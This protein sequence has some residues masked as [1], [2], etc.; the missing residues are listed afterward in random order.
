MGFQSRR[1]RTQ[2]AI[3]RDGHNRFNDFDHNHVHTRAR[4]L[5]YD[6]RL[7][8]LCREVFGDAEWKYTRPTT[9]LNGDMT[10]YDPARAPTFQWPERLKQAKV[11]IRATA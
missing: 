7:G 2:S 4:L 8:A 10:G 3:L 9:R 5:E 11:I 6:P 1:G